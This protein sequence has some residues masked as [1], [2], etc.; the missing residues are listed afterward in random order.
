MALMNSL[1]EREEQAFPMRSTQGPVTS[2]LAR[3]P[4][5]QPICPL[6]ALMEPTVSDLL[7]RRA[8]T[9]AATSFLLRGMLMATELLIC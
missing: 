7:E 2:F 8:T 6:T 3:N 4:G 5:L 1:S 9:I